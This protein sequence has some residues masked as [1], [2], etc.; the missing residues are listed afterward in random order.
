MPAS[1]REA[2]AAI[3]RAALAAGDVTP[4]LQRH[5]RVTGPTLSAGPLTLDLSGVRRVLVLGAGKA[6]ASMT[7]A[8]ETILGDRA[9]E[10]FVVVKDGYR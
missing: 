5:L 2:A 9:R 10:G 6:G 3:W 4:L 8:V 7:R 1:A